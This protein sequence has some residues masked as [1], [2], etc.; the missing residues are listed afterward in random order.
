MWILKNSKDLLENFKSRSFS[1]ISSICTFDFSTLYTTLPHDKLKSRLKELI[2]KAFDNSRYFVVL[3]YKENM[4]R[5]EKAKNF[6]TLT[7]AIS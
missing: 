2:H 1:T 3:G 4:T 6:S 5:I 7:F